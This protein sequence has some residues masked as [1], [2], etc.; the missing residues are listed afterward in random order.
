MNINRNLVAGIALVMSFAVAQAGPKAEDRLTPP[1]KGAVHIGGWLGNRI[2]QCMDKGV[3][4]QNIEALVKPFR[5]K[6]EAGTTDWRSEYWGKWFTSMALGY[7]YAPT[8]ANRKVLDQA[9]KEL[10]ATAAPDGYIG[11]RALDKRLQGWDVWGRKY[12]LLGLIAGYDCT[13]DP[14]LLEAARRH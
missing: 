4:A 7:A 6:L 12:V 1:E 5:V 2:D 8:E 9:L 14:L 11:T 3:A 13:G 10:I